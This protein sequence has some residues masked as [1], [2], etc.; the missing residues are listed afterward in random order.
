M[1]QIFTFVLVLLAW[2]FIMYTAGYDF[3]TRCPTM[4]WLTFAGFTMAYLIA[5]FIPTLDRK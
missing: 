2:S 5:I 1:K 3:T 4:G